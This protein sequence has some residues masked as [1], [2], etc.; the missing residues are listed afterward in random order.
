MEF[1]I[2]KNAKE[3]KPSPENPIEIFSEALEK[4]DPVRALYLSIVDV[5]HAGSIEG[6]VT[7]LSVQASTIFFVQ[8]LNLEIL[9]GGLNQY[10]SNNSG[11][12]I[13]ETAQAVQKIGATITARIFQD[14]IHLLALNEKETSQAERQAHLLKIDP[15]GDLFR[16]LDLEYDEKI[17]SEKSDPREP[18]NIWYLSLEYMKANSGAKIRI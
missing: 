10:F 2:V 9:N 12:Y 16:T 13:K 4:K 15:K 1:K 6:D 14:A 11:S 17:N 5:V 8:L 7:R 3:N 18:E